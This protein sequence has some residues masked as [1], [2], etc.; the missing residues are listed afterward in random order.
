MIN[1]PTITTA[2][3][4]Y[5]NLKWKCQP[6]SN[7]ELVL[8]PVEEGGCDRYFAIRIK[9]TMTNEVYKL[10]KVQQEN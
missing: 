9:I 10:E 1:Y 6:T 4:P 5:C 2:T 3:C 8:C 7:S